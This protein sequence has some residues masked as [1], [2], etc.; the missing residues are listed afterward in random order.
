LTK[1]ATESRSV[2]QKN[3]GHAPSIAKDG[4]SAVNVPT[5]ETGRQIPGVFGGFNPEGMIGLS[6]GF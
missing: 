6:L 3:L 4:A 2:L 5:A 1:D